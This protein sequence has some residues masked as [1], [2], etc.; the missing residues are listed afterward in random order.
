MSEFRFPTGMLGATQLLG[1]MISAIP[2]PHDV[3]IGGDDFE[4]IEGGMAMTVFSPSGDRY[5][6]SVQWVGD[7]ESNQDT[8]PSSDRERG[9]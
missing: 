7:A 2:D 9:S 1:L 8:I 4:A 3:G 6:V 5:R